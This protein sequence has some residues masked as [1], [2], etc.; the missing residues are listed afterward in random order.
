ML[1]HYH[2]HPDHL[3]DYEGGMAECR[4]KNKKSLVQ[5]VLN[6]VPDPSLQ[7]AT[8]TDFIPGGT[9]VKNNRKFFFE[10]EALFSQ[11]IPLSIDMQ[12]LYLISCKAEKILNHFNNFPQLP[13]CVIVKV[14]SIIEFY[15]TWRNLI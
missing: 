4:P 8:S 11:K 6:Q 9:S 12:S 2:H 15:F 1:P 3:R 10:T 13:P 7:H 14:V 5:L